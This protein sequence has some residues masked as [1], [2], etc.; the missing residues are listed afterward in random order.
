MTAPGESG[1]AACDAGAPE[2]TNFRGGG[3]DFQLF[4]G[5][6]QSAPLTAGAAAL[7]ISAYRST[8]GG[9]SPSPQLVKSLL[10][11]T[12][13][14]LGL[15]TFEQGGGPAQ[16]PGRCRGGADLP[17]CEQL[18]AGRCQLEHQPVDQPA[19]PVRRP[20]QHEDRHDRV[21]NVGT[22]EPD[23]R[24][25]HPRLPDDQR[26]RRHT[27]TLNATTDPDLPVPDHRRAVG[28]QEGDLHGAGRNGPVGRRR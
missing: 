18:G 15:P 5:T 8:H 14:D 16:L 4:G 3:S 26:V 9:A 6:S 19:R 27:T 28:L 11:S 21:T 2:C 10:T 23:G 17:G 25:G 7:V 22:Q 20:G 12:A 24:R 1:W 13:T